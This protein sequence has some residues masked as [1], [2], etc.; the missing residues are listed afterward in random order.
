MTTLEQFKAEFG[1]VRLEFQRS[2]K[3]KRQFTTVSQLSANG[4]R[5]KTDVIVAKTIDPKLPKYVAYVEEKNL[6]VV[7]NA[8]G[9]TE[10]DVM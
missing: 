8:K 7:C 1:I 9:V 3:T 5:V 4:I 2:V 6:Y 10:G